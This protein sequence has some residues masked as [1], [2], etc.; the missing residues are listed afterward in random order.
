MTNPLTIT[1]TTWQTDGDGAKE[2]TTIDLTTIPALAA[3]IERNAV[4]EAFRA[5][6]ASITTVRDD[7]EA[8]QDD[9][10]KDADYDEEQAYEDYV[11]DLG[12]DICF[13]HTQTFMQYI[14]DARDL[15]PATDAALIPAV[16]DARLAKLE[17]FVA[18]V[19]GA[20]TMDQVMEDE[21]PADRKDLTREYFSWAESDTLLED[22]DRLDGYITE[23]RELAPKEGGAA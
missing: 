15:A 18:K 1:V 11:C 8:E 5:G 17:A 13:E 4:L 20:V 23:A 14:D 16:P 10:D 3:L 19:A 9:D 21:A 6:I 22:L 7:F 2:S 12:G